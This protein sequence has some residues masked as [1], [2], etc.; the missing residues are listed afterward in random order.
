MMRWVRVSILDLLL[1][2]V[3]NLKLMLVACSLFLSSVSVVI[4]KKLFLVLKWLSS[5]MWILVVSMN[6]SGGKLY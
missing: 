4:G 6:L 2:F 3:K 1:F 5:G